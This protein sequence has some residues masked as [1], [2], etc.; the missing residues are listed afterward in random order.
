MFHRI[1]IK[2]EPDHD[3][4]LENKQVSAENANKFHDYKNK[5]RCCFEAFSISSIKIPIDNI[6]RDAFNK[7]TGVELLQDSGY[8]TLICFDCISN[9]R[10]CQDFIDKS[11]NLQK[12][13]YDFVSTAKSIPIKTENE[14]SD[15]ESV[16]V[17]EADPTDYFASDDDN[18]NRNEEKSEKSNIT[19]ECVVKLEKIDIGDYNVEEYR[20]SICQPTTSIIGKESIKP[21]VTIPR[22]NLTDEQ[23]K[24]LMF[25]DKCDWSSTSKRKM[26]H[27]ALNHA[28]SSGICSFCG[29]VPSSAKG[30]ITHIRRFHR[31]G[32][33]KKTDCSICNIRMQSNYKLEQ[34][35]QLLH[36]EVVKEMPCKK[37]NKSFYTE[38]ALK[39]HEQLAHDVKVKCKD[40]NCE[41][42]FFDQ[43]AMSCHYY[44][45]HLEGT[46]VSYFI[47]VDINILLMKTSYNISA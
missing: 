26:E 8:S 45:M 18:D 35:I 33:S 9:M 12:E 23:K 34:H 39:R 24:L 2:T 21:K 27:H 42:L 25:C 15:S 20:P 16:N 7:L 1:D 40:A 13:F 46:N 31:N 32:K 6:H 5:C 17:V 47:R 44:K 19:K 10:K 43:T 11:R 22:R 29:K 37:C 14:F 38:D 36:P 41:K 28:L 30:L 3:I 4:F